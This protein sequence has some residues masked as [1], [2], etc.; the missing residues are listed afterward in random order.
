MNNIKYYICT[1]DDYEDTGQ[2]TRNPAKMNR[3]GQ[4]IK[5]K[6]KT[7]KLSKAHTVGHE[8]KSLDGTKFI[9]W[10][11]TDIKGQGMFKWMTGN[12]PEFTHAEILEELK[13]PEW[14][15]PEAVLHT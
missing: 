8:R 4:M 15:D 6:W 1:Y 9:T 2:F 3:K 14:F 10:C 5:G 7:K 11:D 12:E 13:G